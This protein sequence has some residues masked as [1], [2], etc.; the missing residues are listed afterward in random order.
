MKLSHPV[1]YA[2]LIVLLGAGNG[3]NAMLGSDLSQWEGVRVPVEN[4]L[5]AENSS[6][7]LIVAGTISKH[8]KG[9]P[10]AVFEHGRFVYRV[11]ESDTGHCDGEPRV[12]VVGPEEIA[13]SWLAYV[14]STRRAITISTADNAH[15]LLTKIGA[16]DNGYKSLKALTA[17]VQQEL[18]WSN[19]YKTLQEA[20]EFT[21]KER[22]CKATREDS[23][24]LPVCQVLAAVFLGVSAQLVY[25]PCQP[26]CPE[27]C[28]ATLQG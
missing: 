23:G 17:A 12:I 22:H 10:V 11:I 24:A 15:E 5:K 27:L 7:S 16:K 25:S 19:E 9:S 13:T 18:S 14:F 28:N 3:L 26:A 6:K 4:R 2:V 20:I 21:I 8:S 1:N